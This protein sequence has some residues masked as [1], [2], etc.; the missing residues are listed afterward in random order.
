MGLA[1]H[2]DPSS[3]HAGY[4]ESMQPPEEEKEKRRRREGE[5]ERRR[6]VHVCTGKKLN[7]LSGYK[8]F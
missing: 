1:Y 3:Q 5:E 4:D 6:R 7:S 2:C 8:Q